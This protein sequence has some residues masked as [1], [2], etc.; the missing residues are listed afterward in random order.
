[1]SFFKKASILLSIIVVLSSCEEAVEPL[2][3]C[4]GPIWASATKNG[5]DLCLGTVKIIYWRANTEGANIALT[6]GTTD[7]VSISE[8]G[9]SFKVP[10]EG[11]AT[12]TVYPLIEGK[13]AGADAFTE[14]SLS[15]INYGS[16]CIA[17]TFELKAVDSIAGVTQTYTNGKFIIDGSEGQDSNCNPFN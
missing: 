3:P 7:K 15:F 4:D 8:I 6:A 9:A 14:G 11:I 17:G 16:G 1:M 13:I 12:N 2:G 5:D 10:I